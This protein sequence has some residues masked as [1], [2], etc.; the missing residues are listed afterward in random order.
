MQAGQAIRGSSCN[1]VS[2]EAG[3]RGDT[4]LSTINLSLASIIFAFGPFPL[5]VGA[6]S[7]CQVP[8]IKKYLS[9]GKIMS[10]SPSD[11]ASRNET[12]SL[13]HAMKAADLIRQQY[14]DDGKIEPSSSSSFISAIPP[15]LIQGVSAFALTAMALVPVRRVLL[16]QAGKEPAFRHFVDLVI[17]VGHALAATQVG[18]LAGSLYGSRCYLDKFAEI[19]PSADSPVHDRICDTLW[20]SILPTQLNE[21]GFRTTN[22]SMVASCD[23][24]I[25]TMESLQHTIVNCQRRKNYRGTIHEDHGRIDLS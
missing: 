19:P 5:P 4:R 22:N 1:N 18:F 13:P 21:S 6:T 15:G 7:V 16:H 12:L 10:S 14:A 25:K 20:R 23:P 17:S 3:K 11:E 9:S 8:R 2:L 24:R